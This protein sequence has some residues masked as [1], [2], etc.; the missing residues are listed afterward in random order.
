MKFRGSRG[1]VIVRVD[2]S[3]EVESRNRMSPLG[4]ELQNHFK[5]HHIGTTGIVY[6]KGD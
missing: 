5:N 1:P 3:G 6:H 4:G 2:S